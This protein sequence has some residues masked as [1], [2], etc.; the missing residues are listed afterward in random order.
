MYNFNQSSLYQIANSKTKSSVNTCIEEMK[1]KGL[2]IGYFGMLAKNI[3]GRNKVKNSEILEL[4]IYGA[5]VEEQSKLEKT[6]LDLFKG[7][8]NYYYEKGQEEVNEGLHK[9]RRVSEM[10]DAFFLSLLDRPNGKGYVWRQYVEAVVKYNADQIYRQCVIHIGQG[11]ENNMEEPVFQNMIR[12]QQNAK[13]CINGDKISGDVDLFLIGF[14]NQAKLQGMYCFDEEAKCKFI[15]VGDDT[16]TKECRSL[17][18]QEFF[19][20]DWNEFYR[21]SK[22]NGGM[23]KC[24]CYG[25]V[26][27]LNL[28][29]IND[30]F[31]W[32]RSTIK[33][34]PVLEKEEKKWYNKLGNSNKNTFGGSGK[35]Q[36][37]EHI[38]KEQIEQKLKE[39]E[40][41]IRN[42]PIEYGVLIDENNDVY[43]YQGTETNLNICDRSLDNVILT[44]NHPE[45]CSF[46]ED[47]YVLLEKNPKIKELRAVDKDYTYSLKIL[48]TFD[49]PYNDFYRKGLGL[50]YRTHEEVQH[51]VMLELEREGYIKYDRKRNREM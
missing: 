24:R 43:A 20:H 3:Y 25:L 9:K 15:S 6:E 44:H 51:C 2:L 30:G 26:T 29:P 48:K 34:L 45:V 33:Y 28:P 13:L 37:I 12:K 11:K 1:D 38:D 27:G 42:M 22:M 40:E 31:H 50:V 10:S 4:L 14:N 16:T 46:G 21:Y 36:F 49:K 47:D 18:G 19:V 17:N 7:V 35:G 41:D 32:C 8:A 5:Y 39:Y 23:V